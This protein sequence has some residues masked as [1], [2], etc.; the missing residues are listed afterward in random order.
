MIKPEK[1]DVV[2]LCGGLGTRLRAV[3]SDR[4]KSLAEISGKPFLDLLINYV[5]MFG[6]RRF[7][8][9][10]GYKGEMVLDYYKKQVDK[11]RQILISR[12]EKPLGTAGA[13]KNAERFLR[14]DP[15]LVI[16][17]DSLCSVDLKNFLKFHEENKAVLSIILT[18]A[19]HG[20]DCGKIILD[21]KTKEITN[22]AEKRKITN[23]GLTN[24]GIYL[25]SK[26]LLREIPKKKKVSLENDFFP[27]LIGRG[28]FGKVVTKDFIDIGTPERFRMFKDAQEN[29]L[30]K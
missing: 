19:I 27:K 15:F 11:K 28:L 20:D 13:I 5:S 14:S 4:P 26:D 3:V 17:G 1:V 22:F 10:V 18:S 30:I 2:V 25:F 7:I 8:L 24:M 21:K 6:F 12:E 23:K 9:C 29:V 16:N